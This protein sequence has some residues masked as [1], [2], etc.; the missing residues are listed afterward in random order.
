MKFKREVAMVLNYHC[1]PLTVVLGEAASVVFPDKLIWKF[2][3]TRPGY[4]KYFVHTHP[5]GMPLMS[6]EDRTTLKAWTQA[7]APHELNF[8]VVSVKGPGITIVNNWYKIE[9]LEV[10]R[11]LGKKGERKMELFRESLELIDF[12]KL[13]WLLT[14]LDLSYDKMT[15]L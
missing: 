6:E 3:Y 9:D 10:W 5:P 7:M 12:E 13:D 11:S 8:L 2:H 1:N 15:V 14:L 4:I